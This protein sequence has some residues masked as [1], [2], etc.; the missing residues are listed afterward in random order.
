L[1]QI[2]IVTALEPFPGLT[3]EFQLVQKVI[4]G[5]R[6]LIPDSI[7]PAVAALISQCRDK[8]PARRPTFKEIIFPLCG[9]EFLS[10]IHQVIFREYQLPVSPAELSRPATTPA[11]APPIAIRK[12]IAR[13]ERGETHQEEQRPAETKKKPTGI[14]NFTRPPAAVPRR[15]QPVSQDN[16]PSW[17]TDPKANTVS[18]PKGSIQSNPSKLTV[19]N[20]EPRQSQF[21]K[22]QN[23][24]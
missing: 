7:P 2:T 20:A 22:L 8:D 13:S 14:K 17:I 10:S 12:K 24:N 5:H 19:P 16:P 18:C 4:T 11:A 23:L 6:P 3:I 21:Q 15:Q 1:L 9:E